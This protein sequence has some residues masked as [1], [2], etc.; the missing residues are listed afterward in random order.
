LIGLCICD[1]TAESGLFS[2]MKKECFTMSSPTSASVPSPLERMSSLIS[3]A[4]LVVGSNSALINQYRDGLDLPAIRDKQDEAAE[5]VASV[6]RALSH[7][8]N[9]VEGVGVQ[10]SA[11]AAEIDE[12]TRGIFQVQLGKMRERLESSKQIVAFCRFDLLAGDQ[13]L[14]LERRLAES[15]EKTRAVLARHAAAATEAKPS[16]QEI[17]EL[18]REF[19]GIDRLISQINDMPKASAIAG[20]LFNRNTGAL[21]QSSRALFD[22]LV[23]EMQTAFGSK[24]VDSIV[25]AEEEAALPTLSAQPIT[26]T[27][28]EVMELQHSLRYLARAAERRHPESTGT[29][30]LAVQEL[31]GEMAQARAQIL[32]LLATLPVEFTSELYGQVYH[33]S[34][35]P[36]G[37]PQWG[38]KNVLKDPSVTLRALARVLELKPQFMPRILDASDSPVELTETVPLQAVALPTVPFVLEQLIQKLRALVDDTSITEPAIRGGWTALIFDEAKKQLGETAGS[39]AD[40]I[41][42]E[43]YKA[44]YLRSRSQR[45]R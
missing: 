1:Y 14:A 35:E 7:L 18:C 23:A 33:C 13:M 39:R 34:P 10:L 37:G 32:V 24:R 40:K 4:L 44:V 20:V 36:K 9:T 31:E 16:E 29:T 21:F 38:E 25:F 5:Q 42:G 19:Y 17:E 15:A 45:R 6:S 3:E 41:L 27:N 30:E 28:S 22:K 8:Q 2:K 43:I 12:T 26:W 11:C